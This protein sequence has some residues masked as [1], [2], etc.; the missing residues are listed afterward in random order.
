MLRMIPL[1]VALV[2]A[3]AAWA[4]AEP[5]VDDANKHA[6]AH[7]TVLASDLKGIDVEDSTGEN[8]GKVVDLM[9][10]CHG[11]RVAFLL[12]QCDEMDDRQFAVPVGKLDLRMDGD[13]YTGRIEPSVLSTLP[14]VKEGDLDAA[15]RLRVDDAGKTRDAASTGKPFKPFSRAV[16]LKVLDSSGEKIGEIHDLVI[17]LDD[18]RV[19]YALVDS[20]GVMGMG[21]KTCAVPLSAFREGPKDDQ[22]SLSVTKQQLESAPKA[23]KDHANAVTFEKQIHDHFAG[24]A[25]RRDDGR[26]SGAVSVLKLQDVLGKKVEDHNGDKIGDVKDVLLDG[27]DGQLTVAILSVGGFLGIGDKNVAVPFSALQRGAD[28]TLTLDVTKETLE[29]S[30]GIDDS[31][32]DKLTDSAYCSAV[33]RRYG[34]TDHLSI[35]CSSVVKAAD[36]LDSELTTSSGEEIGSVEDLAIDPDDGTLRYAAVS[37]KDADEDLFAVNWNEIRITPRSDE[38]AL[39]V[40]ASTLRAE[41]GFSKDQWPRTLEENRSRGR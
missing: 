4:N 38:V 1:S 28:D 9:I 32:Y 30:E 31:S 5:R 10:D 16:D 17:H 24:T 29:E 34:M 19:A 33:A 3:S 21:E 7:G 20:G 40:D 25:S 22:I 14:S 39:V 13:D 27:S 6:R 8:H 41:R 37:L 15:A 11:E 18:G 12:V 23:P 35:H 36:V 2:A 26:G